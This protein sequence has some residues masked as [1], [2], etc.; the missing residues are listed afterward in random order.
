[1]TLLSGS[2]PQPPESFPS[3]GPTPP[4]Q[5]T[6]AQQST[7]QFAVTSSSP[8]SGPASG[9]TLIVIHGSGFSSVTK[10]VMNSTEP[11]L[12]I[13]SPN[14]D[15]QNLHPRFKVVSDSEIDVTTTAGAPGFTYEIDFITPTAEYFSNTWPGIPLYT[16]N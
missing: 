6:P 9:G 3:L 1:M 10:V 2:P 7:G 12:P 13:G 14:Y 16:F 5:P 11:P 8:A 4:A 15:L